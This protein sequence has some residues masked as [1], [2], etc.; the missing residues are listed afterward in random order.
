MSTDLRDAMVISIQGRWRWGKRKQIVFDC[1]TIEQLKDIESLG[2]NL[3]P[4]AAMMELHIRC[5]V[6]FEIVLGSPQLGQVLLPACRTRA[7]ALWI[8]LVHFFQLSLLYTPVDTMSNV[9][10]Q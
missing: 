3:G 5:I 2:V 7:E 8:H 9:C 10:K 4:E 6:M 1:Q